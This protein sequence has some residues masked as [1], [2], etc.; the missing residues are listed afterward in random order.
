MP[1]SEDTQVSCALG[2]SWKRSDLIG[3]WDRP[4]CWSWRVSW[5]VRGTCSS[6]WGQGHWWQG[7]WG[8][9][10][11]TKAR[12]HPIYPLG[13]S[14]G[15]PQAK[16]P[17]GQKHSPTHHHT[18]K[19]S[20]THTPWK[21]LPTRGTRPSSTQQWAGTSPSHQEVYTSPL[22]QPHPPKG[23]HQKKQELQSCSLWNRKQKVR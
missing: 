19:S 21:A 16:Q 4:T 14:V 20:W 8:V 9:F 12:P 10:A 2:P 23:R 15:K 6:L 18:A 17:T 13:S 11:G 5:E 7:C 22:D 1:F 3:A